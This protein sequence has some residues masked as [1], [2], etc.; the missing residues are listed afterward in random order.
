MCERW[1]FKRKRNSLNWEERKEILCR[2]FSRS[3]EKGTLMRISTFRS[4]PV[5]VGKGDGNAIDGLTTERWQQKCSKG[6][7]NE[8]CYFS[9]NSAWIRWERKK[10]VDREILKKCKRQK[11]TP[12]FYAVR[13][14]RIKFNMKTACLILFVEKQ[15]QFTFPRVTKK[16]KTIIIITAFVRIRV[17]QPSAIELLFVGKIFWTFSIKKKFKWQS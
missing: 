16:F 12:Q 15:S 17:S 3:R 14:K 10:Q 8:N 9:N 13:K 6:M 2:C 5:W 4:F 1:K 7:R 11:T